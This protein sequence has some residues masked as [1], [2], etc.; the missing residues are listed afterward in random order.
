MDFIR[1]EIL[2]H[3]NFIYPDNNEHPCDK[4]LLV[5]N[6]NHSHPDDV[7]LIPCKTKTVQDTNFKDWC[8][9]RYDV[10]YFPSQIGFYK[11][12]TIVQ[13][14]HIEKYYCGEIEDMIKNNIIDRLNKY[15]TV[16]EMG[17][18]FNCLRKI[19]KD[20]SEEIWNLIS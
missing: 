2:Y 17:R 6:R 9:E 20:I 4:L 13:L 12:Q 8:D 5:V 16:E 18:I 7:V 15:L 19:K 1:S 10:F 3:T 14:Y 11:A